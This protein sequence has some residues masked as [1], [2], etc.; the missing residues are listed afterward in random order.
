MNKKEKILLTIF[1]V[2]FYVIG[3]FVLIILNKNNDKEISPDYNPIVN[4]IENDE[5][6]ISEIEILKNDKSCISN[7]SNL[8]KNKEIQL[9]EGNGK[10]FGDIIKIGTEKFYFISCK[11]NE[12]KLFSMYNLQSGGY[13]K[14]NKY[15]IYTKESNLQDELM[16][17]KNDKT[18]PNY[19]GVIA[20]SSYSPKYEDSDVKKIVDNYAK[21]I[22]NTYNISA[23][24]DLF[25]NRDLDNIGL[26]SYNFNDR[27]NPILK[28]NI[29]YSTSYWLKN[30][31]GSGTIWTVTANSGFLFADHFS[32]NKYYGVRPL[33]IINLD[34]K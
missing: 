24:G 21:Y 17:G 16:L 22:S 2:Q 26:S 11:N 32:V 34:R 5:Y 20:F 3:I 6:T 33:L 9:I 13:T 7:L 4:K 14:N 30:H 23:K 19:N 27:E 31:N 18:F 10:N 12:L 8:Y 25:T 15:I 29:L 28:L 1:I